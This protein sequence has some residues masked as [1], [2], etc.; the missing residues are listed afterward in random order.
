[1]ATTEILALNPQNVWK[2]FYS[3]TQI[4]R[5]TG[6]MDR[7][8]RF[9]LDFGKLLNLETKQDKAG[10]VL[11][12]KPASKGYEMAKTVILQSHLDMVPQKN[13]GVSHDFASD[14]IE[15]MID[16]EWVKAHAT[17]L[18]ADNGIGCALMMAVLEDPSLK[19][20]AIEALFTVDEE[21]GM[22]GANG[23]E[24]NML[25]GS[26]MLN[27]DTEEDG[28]LCIGCAGGRDVNISFRFQADRNIEKGDIAFKVS[29]K[30]LKGGHSGVQIHLGRANANKLMNRFL[31]DV[32]RNY[33]A[34]IA[35]IQGG[36]LRNAIPRE[37]FV[38]LT[39]PEQLS[40]DLIDLVGEYEALFREDFSGIE[41]GISFKAERTDLPKTILPEEIQDDLIN[42][43]EGCPNGVI[44]YLADFP[45]VVES[46]LNLA[47]I[48]TSEES[49]EVK[50]LVRS[51]SESRKNWVCSSVESLFLLAGAKV[52]FDGDY[53]GWQPNANSEL[54]RLMERIYLE[55]YDQR[56]K[57]MV[58]HAGLECGI[59]Q[60]N[61]TQK[62]DIVSFGPTITGAHSPD[63][64]VKIESVGKSYEYLLTIL[65]KMN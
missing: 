44:S 18:G 27:L 55:K 7:V 21:V 42:A 59:I 19:H 37:S 48:Q 15:T 3:L 12:R 34:R 46:S 64:A 17:T 5:P 41:D 35:S 28:E 47:M 30:G 11:I 52:E 23:L 14:P 54:L 24:G 53:P 49:I 39:I 6:Q 51:S 1:M 20:P 38:V 50:L 22:D 58:I 13:S 63:E 62:L 61:V 56:P 16:G 40:D 36:S 43:V 45:G 29:L 2:H 33:E 31:K 8:T 57:V 25:E 9:V 4:P 60:S 10:N 26:L 65:E 32:I